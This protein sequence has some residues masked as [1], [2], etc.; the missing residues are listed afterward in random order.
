MTARPAYFDRYET[1][2][3][4]RSDNGVLV[5]R[6]HSNGGP[7]L[8]GNVHHSE[9]AP[10]FTDIGMDRNNRIVIFTGTGNVFIDRHGTWT[11]PL[12]TPK[13]FDVP[14]WGEKTMFQRM[15]EIEAPVIC[16]CNGPALIHGELMVLGDINL[17]ADT[18]V[19]ADEGHFTAGEVPGDGVHLIWQELLGPNRGKY[20][21]MTGQH[22]DAQAALEYGIVNEVLKPQD[23]MPRALELANQMATYSD[24]TL[25]YTRLCFVDRWKRLF[26]ESVGVG[27]GMALQGLSH[28]D[29][30]WM[31]W[32]KTNEGHP[33][34]AQLKVLKPKSKNLRPGNK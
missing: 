34:H 13:D 8:Y 26:H 4:E 15:F 23:L 30:G 17:A 9:W 14:M 19:F 12:R 33:D 32:N 2:A 25:R 16:A 31:V 18:A 21:L 28:L 29:R 6:Y 10:A 3:F 5:V 7:V 27:Y 22:L 11:A 24:L 1:L 20:F